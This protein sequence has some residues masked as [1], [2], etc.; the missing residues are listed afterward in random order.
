LAERC[1][2]YINIIYICVCVCVCYDSVII[3]ISL[4]SLADW[5]RVYSQGNIFPFSQ[6]IRYTPSWMPLTHRRRDCHRPPSLYVGAK[7]NKRYCHLPRKSI[8]HFH[9]YVGSAGSQIKQK[10]KCIEKTSNDYKSFNLYLSRGITN[11]GYC[12]Y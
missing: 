10:N 5:L 1:R 12:W 6:L 9:L 3:I 7:P 4:F 8:S 11:S 2:N